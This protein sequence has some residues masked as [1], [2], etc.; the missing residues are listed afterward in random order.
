MSFQSD[1]FQA[2]AFQIEEVVVLTATS[3]TT[4]SFQRLISKPLTATL[5]AT[6]TVQRLV[7][8]TLA[9]AVLTVAII[10]GVRQKFVEVITRQMASISITLRERENE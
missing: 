10:V 8:K 6:A 2:D 4:A 7:S 5:A 9:A 3:T 1:A